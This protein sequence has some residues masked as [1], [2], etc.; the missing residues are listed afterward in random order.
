MVSF[1]QG[2]QLQIKAKL[3]LVLLLAL[4]MVGDGCNPL[5]ADSVDMLKDAAISALMI[6]Y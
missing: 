4:I 2:R 5:G 1:Y 6:R 3:L